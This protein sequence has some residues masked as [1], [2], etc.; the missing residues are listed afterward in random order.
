LTSRASATLWSGP[1][2]ASSSTEK[3]MNSGFSAGQWART[4]STT[5]IAK[6]IRFNSLPPY[7]SLRRL[8]NGE[9]N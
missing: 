5:S 9:R 6:R 2:P 7:S 4:L 1:Q 8:E 3:R